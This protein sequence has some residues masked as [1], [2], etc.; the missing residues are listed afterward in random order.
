MRKTKEKILCNFCK[1]EFETSEGKQRG[2]K[3][4]C[5]HCG[6]IARVIV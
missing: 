2:N 6:K 1:K 4:Y 3:L 5:T